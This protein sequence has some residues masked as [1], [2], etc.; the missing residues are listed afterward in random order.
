MRS[1]HEH[2]EKQHI[3]GNIA[4]SATKARVEVPR[5]QTLEYPDDHCSNDGACYAVEPADDNDREYFEADQRYPKATTRY[6]RPQHPG[7]HRNHA[8]GCPDEREMISD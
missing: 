5:S 2:N 3:A 7:D 8:G 4:K 6:E 1:Q